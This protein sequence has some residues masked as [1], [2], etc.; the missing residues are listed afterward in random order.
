MIPLL[1]TTNAIKISA[2]EAVLAAAGVTATVF[3]R[4]AGALWTAI[5]PMRVMV[6]AEEA[7][8]ARLALRAA[9]FIPALDG[10]WDLTT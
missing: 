2:V 8:A 1:T 3:D 5:I 9:G 7:G 10:D 6:S 4:A